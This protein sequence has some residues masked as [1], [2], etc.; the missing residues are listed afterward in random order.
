MSRGASARL[1]VAVDPPAAVCD[2]LA[3]WARAALGGRPHGS[4]RRRESGRAHESDRRR[5]GERH[6]R[7]G[8]ARVRLLGAHT[9]HVT[10]CFLGNRAVGEIEPIA[11]ALEQAAQTADAAI[12]G[13]D[14]ALGAPL[15]LPPRRPRSLALEVHDAG[16]ALARV[17]RSLSD[18]IARAIGWQP[19]RRR[20]RAHVTVAR[21]GRGADVGAGAREPLAPSP[22]LSFVAREVV[23]YRSLLSPD[24]AS[25]EPLAASALG[26]AGQP[27]SEASPAEGSSLTAPGHA[28]S[29][30]SSDE[31]GAAPS[32][33]CDGDPAS[34][35]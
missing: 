6:G 4:E 20:F 32:S 13:V 2:E 14:L 18:A 12:A 11:D 23:L 30:P 10:L 22:Q 29:A 21:L 35:A 1:F 16:G 8:A 33:H 28:S 34:Q 24:G 27:P 5:G 7:G 25:Y 9:M 19:E 15:W 26:G 31:T 3:A 17:Q